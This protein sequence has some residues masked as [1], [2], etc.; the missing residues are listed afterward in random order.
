MHFH[1]INF[2]RRQ[3]LDQI[4]ESIKQSRRLRT[5]AKLNLQKRNALND[6]AN[7]LDASNVLLRQKVGEIFSRIRSDKRALHQLHL[8]TSAKRKTQTSRMC[9]QYEAAV[10]LQGWW[11]KSQH[12]LSF[13][14]KDQ[15]FARQDFIFR[16]VN[17]LIKSGPQPSIL[18]I[19]MIQSK[20]IDIGCEVDETQ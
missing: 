19:P 6:Q 1:L 3:S 4:M 13:Q 8:I 12:G 5:K 17:D 15:L 11:Q 20:I 9:K 2:K 18:Q 10:A 14:S 16:Y 7:E